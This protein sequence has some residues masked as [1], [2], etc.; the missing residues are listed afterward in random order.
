MAAAC[1]TTQVLAPPPDMHEAPV[2]GIVTGS[3][4]MSPQIAGD[5]EAD[6]DEAALASVGVLAE[7][8]IAPGVS[9]NLPMRPGYPEETTLV[10]TLVARHADRTQVLQSVLE[11]NDARARVVLMAANGP[12]IMELV[13]TEEGVVE[14]RSAF[15]PDALNGLNILA[16]VYLSTWPDAQVESALSDGVSLKVDTGVRHIM[17]G[18]TLVI[19]V[20]DMGVDPRGRQRVVLENHLL[21][22]TLEIFSQAGGVG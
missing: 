2:E 7:V 1:Q 22:Y 5:A 21:G 18:E 6:V 15:A 10:Q 17:K 12:R 20:R 3:A 11:L 16:D 13:W 4:E 8:L 19:A 14:T 9:L